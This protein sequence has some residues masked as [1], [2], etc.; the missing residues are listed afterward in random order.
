M[1][2]KQKKPNKNTGKDIRSVRNTSRKL[3]IGKLQ[4]L[5]KIDESILTLK[6]KISVFLHNRL[7][8]FWQQDK[9]QLLDLSKQFNDSTPYLSAWEIQTLFAE[10]YNHY[11]TMVTQRKNN[12][13]IKYIKGYELTYYKQDTKTNKKGDLKSRLPIKVRTKLSKLL[14]YLIEVPDDFN[15]ITNPEIV[16]YIEHYK[17]KEMWEKVEKFARVIQFEIRK[18]CKV[19]EYTTGT[20]KKAYKANGRT[21]N[22]HFLTD[23]SNSLY[24][25]WYMYQI[26][27]AKA[28]YMPMLVNEE[29]QRDM[30]RAAI[31]R[32][33]TFKNRVDVIAHKTVDLTFQEF[34]KVVGVDLNAKHNIFA[35]SDNV[36]YDFDRKFIHQ[37]VEYYKKLERKGMSNATEEQLA[38]LNKIILRNESMIKLA[39]GQMLND[40]VASGVTDIVVEDLNGF[41]AT[42][43]YNQDFK[44]KY[45]KLVRLIRLSSVKDWLKGQAEKRGI[46]VHVTHA[47]YSSQTCPKCHNIHKGNRETQEL[48]KCINAKC[49]HTAN[50]DIV[51]AVNLKNRYENVSIR[52]ELHKVDK[53]GR[54]IPKT[55]RRDSIKEKLLEYNGVTPS[56][57]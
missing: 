39:I 34:N 5:Q 38:K 6:N 57:V 21:L 48:F 20:H 36:F 22:S 31:C 18:S 47:A 28:I 46:R 42:F 33:K 55:L 12:K 56:V 52:K 15:S 30:D 7:S 32:I 26:P 49:N 51:A 19:I 29:Y 35:T 9:K 41:S 25:E 1:L 40:L 14:N 8:I 10:I 44:I 16:S 17:S 53:F 54:L 3:N 50:A 4:L 23:G 43:A 24:K 45:S 11:D 37:F 2:A 13:D 27:G